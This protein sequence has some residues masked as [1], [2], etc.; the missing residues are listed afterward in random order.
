MNQQEQTQQQNTYNNLQNISNIINNTNDNN[1]SWNRISKISK[2]HKIYDY[3]DNV[4][5]QK[6]DLTDDEVKELKTYLRNSIDRK[7]LLK[8]KELEYDKEK[9]VIINIP[10]LI[11]NKKNNHKF[12]LR[13]GEKSSSLK[14][15]A[16][17]KNST[18]KIKKT[19]K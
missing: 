7:N 12:T 5:K 19:K 17:K 3:V 10:S 11:I 6:E 13:T 4:L 8:S 1:K 15:L 16:P 9:A 18:V 2:I 14:N